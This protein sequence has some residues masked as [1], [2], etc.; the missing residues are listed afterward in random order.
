MLNRDRRFAAA[1]DK[2]PAMARPM[3]R[4]GGGPPP[5]EDIGLL[6]LAGKVK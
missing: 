3:A 5:L 2:T 1:P 6:E 4:G